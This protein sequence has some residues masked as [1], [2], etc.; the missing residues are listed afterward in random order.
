[1]TTT[2]LL[3]AGAALAIWALSRRRP[4]RQETPEERAR[5]EAQMAREAW[6]QRYRNDTK[7]KAG[8]IRF[9]KAL[10]QAMERERIERERE[11]ERDSF[12]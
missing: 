1:M 5:R 2:L 3:L 11:R 8:Q 12:Q 10:H 4:M 6:L 7:T 9:I